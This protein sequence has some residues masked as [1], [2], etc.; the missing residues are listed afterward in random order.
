VTDLWQRHTSRRDRGVA[1]IHRR[2]VW[3]T[4]AWI[5]GG[6]AS[7]DAVVI[8][9]PIGTENRFRIVWDVVGKKPRIL[10]EIFLERAK[11][12]EP[13][14]PTLARLWFGIP[15]AI[16]LG[17]E[18]VRKDGFSLIVRLSPTTLSA[19]RCCKLTFSCNDVA[20]RLPVFDR[21]HV[22]DGH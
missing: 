16:P 13:T 20:A 7:V 3:R 15:P 17:N 2:F 5:A 11:G 18:Y 19:A 22:A 14:T 12:F 4:G 21:P 8:T 1:Q 10:W 6:R 9:G